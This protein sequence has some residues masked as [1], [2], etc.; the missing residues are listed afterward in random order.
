M[1]LPFELVPEP[2]PPDLPGSVVLRETLDETLDAVAAD[3]L[4]Q[5]YACVRAFGD[6]HL[7]VSVGPVQETLYLRLL[8]DPTYRDL[9]WKR[10]HLWLIDELP[11]GAEDERSHFSQ[12]RDILVEHADI[13]RGQVHAAR[14]GEPDAAERYETELRE[15][16]VWREKGHDRIDLAVVALGE[17]GSIGGLLPGMGGVHGG[18]VA[19]APD[20]RV[21]MTHRLLNSSRLIQA[22]A[23]GEA[24]RPVIAQL[25]ERRVNRVELPAAGLKPLA[26]T[27]R[28]YLDRAAAPVE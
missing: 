19:T 28:W 11:L 15:S 6:F 23:T 10:T 27:L 9:P 12:I 8:T 18:L 1:S 5:A 21:T 26:G 22:I 25:V 13:P 14:G 3:L 16:L 7:A 2:T 24:A 17:D 4:M 20:G